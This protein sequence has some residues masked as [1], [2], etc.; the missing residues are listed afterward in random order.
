MISRAYIISLTAVIRSSPH[1][2]K[3]TPPQS[4]WLP[5]LESQRLR[6]SPTRTFFPLEAGSPS[7]GSRVTSIT[8]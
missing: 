2:P 4:P 6:R 1:A 3:P 7:S 8:G 5:K